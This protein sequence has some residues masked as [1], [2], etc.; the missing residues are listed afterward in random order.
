MRGGLRERTT[1][2]RNF[3]E[4]AENDSPFDFGEDRVPIFNEQHTLSH[5]RP[6]VRITLTRD[7]P[8]IDAIFSWVI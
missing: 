4:P 2:R 6:S 3:G 1:D 8:V 7:V 5:N